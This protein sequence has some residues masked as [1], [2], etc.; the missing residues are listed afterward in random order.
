MQLKLE[1]ITGIPAGSQVLR[2]ERTSDEAPG[3][4]GQSAAAPDASQVVGYLSDEA[5]TLASYGPTDY[6]TIRVDTTDP[7]IKARAGQFTDVSLV[8]K[9]E[10]TEEEYDKRSGEQPTSAPL[11]SALA[12]L[13]RPDRLSPPR[14]AADTVRS[15]KLR[16]QLGRFAPSVSDTASVFSEAD[17]PA[18]LAPGARCEVSL[19]DELSRR[20]TVRFVGPTAFGQADAS[21]WVGVEW[22][23]PVGKN[24]GA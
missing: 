22:D 6:M 8:D 15:F 16:H 11:T 23:E 13:T 1:P 9:F 20:G 2:L 4:S 3:H 21:V 7:T 18:E 14:T 5:R 17:V 19:S 12:S 10:L 24:D